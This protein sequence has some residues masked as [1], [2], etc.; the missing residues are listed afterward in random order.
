MKRIVNLEDSKYTL[1]YEEETGKFYALRYGEPWRDIYDGMVL[2]MFHE[3]EN[4]R[5]Q[6]C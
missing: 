6:K 3:I 1:I 5:S 2:A 4:L